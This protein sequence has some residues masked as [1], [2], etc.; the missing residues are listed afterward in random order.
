[1]LRSMHHEAVNLDHPA[2]VPPVHRS[3]GP[4]MRILMVNKYL[5]L[6]GGAEAHM[7]QIGRQLQQAGHT[8]SYFGMD[9][10]EHPVAVPTAGTVPEVDYEHIAHWHERGKAVLDSIYSSAAYQRIRR[11]V[12]RHGPH[13]AHAH[14]IYHQLSP[15]VLVA[16]KREGMP[17]LMTAHDYKLICPTYLMLS[18][19]GYCFRCRTGRYRE[20]LRTGCARHGRAAAVAHMAEAYLHRAWQIY[21]RH[22][23][24]VIAPS[25]FLRDRLVE[26]GWP[27]QDIRVLPNP[28]DLDRFSPAYGPGDYLLFVGRLSPEKGLP[29]L[30][31]AAAQIPEVPLW[32]AGDGPERERLEQEA[33]DRGLDKVRFLG[34]VPQRRVVELLRGCRALLLP[35]RSPENC[36]LSVLEAF[37]CGKPAVGSRLGGVPE[38]IEPAEA[39]WTA[40]PDDPDAWSDAMAVAWQDPDA[41][42]E[43]GRAGRRWVESHHDLDAYCRR[44]EGIYRELLSEGNG[45]C[46]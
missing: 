33:R 42:I 8:L 36:P 6:K 11:A 46:A 31:E 2:A 12:R 26:A 20:I 43:R 14:N 1:M 5:Y 27:E 29:T 28:I 39:G 35:S 22:L 10:A 41:C 32:I 15:S 19:D 18:P 24:R 23:D 7:L 25:R 37:A 30:L 13:L 38:L 4:A 45:R 40:Q 16:L 21:S 9:S 3:A 17:T 44:L 34:Q